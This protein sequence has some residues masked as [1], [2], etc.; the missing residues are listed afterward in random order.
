MASGAHRFTSC[1]AQP[2]GTGTAYDASD[3]TQQRKCTQCVG[4]TYQDSASHTD[5]QCKSQSTCPA[6]MVYAA[7]SDKTAARTCSSCTGATYKEGSNYVASC[8][9]QPFCGAGQQMSSNSFTA[10]RTCSPC[11]ALTYQDASSHRGSCKP[12]GGCASNQFVAAECAASASPTQCQDHSTCPDNEYQVNAGT[13][14]A[15]TDCGAMTDCSSYQY[16]LT[17]PTTTSDR[18]CRALATC[19]SEIGR[20][21][22]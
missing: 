16:E 15:D 18:V 14:T 5:A 4:Y 12:C 20:A 17:A 8:T 11:A 6:G 9:D 1:K 21:H 19:L 10:P 7:A 13:D 2:C 3:K 22:V